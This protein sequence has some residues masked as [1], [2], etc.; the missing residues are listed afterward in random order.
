MAAQ[1]ENV[2]LKARGTACNRFDFE[3]KQPVS[4]YLRNVGATNKKIMLEETVK[5]NLLS[6]SLFLCIPN[7]F[8]KSTALSPIPI[9]PVG[10]SLTSAVCV[11]M[12]TQ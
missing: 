4:F 9:R 10:H 3:C 6:L 1:K 5:E 11:H 12:H 2:H 8:F 7:R